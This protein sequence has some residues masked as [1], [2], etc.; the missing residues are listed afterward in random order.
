MAAGRSAARQAPMRV[1]RL[2]LTTAKIRAL[3][4]L[5]DKRIEIP[6][7]PGYRLFMGRVRVG[8]LFAYTDNLSNKAKLVAYPDFDGDALDVA[9]PID[10]FFGTNGPDVGKLVAESILGRDVD[11]RVSAST[12]FTLGSINTN[13]GS[14]GPAFS[15]LNPAVLGDVTLEILFLHATVREVSL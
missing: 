4:A 6:T 12:G 13:D 3:G 11:P 7:P 15:T 5:T 8:V 2:R 10:A 9:T 14:A 1:H